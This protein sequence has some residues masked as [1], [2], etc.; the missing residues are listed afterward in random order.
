MNMTVAYPR[1]SFNLNAEATVDLIDARLDLVMATFEIK[2]LLEN[3]SKYRH[4][5]FPVTE[6]EFLAP[7]EFARFIRIIRR[8]LSERK[9]LE[10]EKR[11]AMQQRKREKRTR[12]EEMR[13]R[14]RMEREEALRERAAHEEAKRRTKHKVDNEEVFENLRDLLRGFIEVTNEMREAVPNPDELEELVNP[15][16]ENLRTRI[17]QMFGGNAHG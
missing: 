15:V 7:A 12:R 1:F 11:M 3:Q 2:K 16:R 6:G 5:D 4:A 13:R 14:H 17:E 10:R 9:R 8:K